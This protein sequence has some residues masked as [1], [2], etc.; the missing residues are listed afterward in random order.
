PP[1]SAP[2]P[3]ETPP[4]WQPPDQSQ[5]SREATERNGPGRSAAAGR[6]TSPQ[7][8][9]QPSGTKPPAPAP[10]ASRPQTSSK[11]DLCF[12][13]EGFIPPAPP[14]RFPV[15]FPARAG[16]GGEGNGKKIQ[17][18]NRD[19]SGQSVVRPFFADLP[20]YPKGVGGAARHGPK[21]EKGVAGGL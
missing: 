2:E 21:N 9:K 18:R 17:G 10:K 1:P 4:E 6:Q 5:T 13:Q 20:R 14:F 15:V 19:A 16:A 11:S 7:P 12:L 3:K 8:G